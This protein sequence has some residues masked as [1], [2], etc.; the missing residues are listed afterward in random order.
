MSIFQ[1]FSSRRTELL[2]N[3]AT[4]KVKISPSNFLILLKIKV[5]WE[6][7]GSDNS[8]CGRILS[9]RTLVFSFAKLER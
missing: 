7:G 8:N 2:Q 4:T 3:G 6:V 1:D 9:M 5:I